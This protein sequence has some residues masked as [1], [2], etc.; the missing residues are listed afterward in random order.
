MVALDI[1]MSTGTPFPPSLQN[2]TTAVSTGHGR[3]LRWRLGVVSLVT[4]NCF[5]ST[6]SGLRCSC[7]GCRCSHR[8]HYPCQLWSWAMMKR[9]TSTVACVTIARTW[10]FDG[11]PSTSSGLRWAHMDFHGS[12]MVSHGLPW[13]SIDLPWAF[14]DI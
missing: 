9:R 10:V 12:P 11:L 5:L 3:L 1:F 2:R 8:Q 14:M 6:H 13:T 7:R 4:G